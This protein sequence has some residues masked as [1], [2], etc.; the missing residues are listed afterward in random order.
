[1]RPA[2]ALAARRGKFGGRGIG[3]PVFDDDSPSEARRQGLLP[4]R[5]G[6][7]H[8][9][10]RKLDDFPLGTLVI[11]R[12]KLKMLQCRVVVAELVRPPTQ[13]SHH[14]KFP[15]ALLSTM[16]KHRSFFWRFLL[17]QGLP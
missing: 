2:L 15:C 3:S 13:L 7:P 12:R 6:E 5:H 16:T 9:I 1:R 10:E 17:L 14:T 4:F 8:P 11:V